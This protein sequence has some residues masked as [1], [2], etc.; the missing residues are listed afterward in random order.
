M[1]STINHTIVRMAK[2]I[3]ITGWSTRRKK[4]CWNRNDSSSWWNDCTVYAQT[5]LADSLF[6]ICE[7][8]TR[9]ARLP[10]KIWWGVGVNRSDS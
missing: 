8:A 3:N 6:L 9:K 1:K 4:N 5:T 10:K 7:V 2:A